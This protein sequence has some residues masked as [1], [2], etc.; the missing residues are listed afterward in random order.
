MS[1]IRKDLSL[2]QKL[3]ILDKI[4]LQPPGCSTRRLSEILGV[5]KSTIARI[6]LQEQ[7]LREQALSQ[8]TTRK[9]KRE[10]KDADVDEALTQWF[11]LATSRGVQ[12]SGPILK[13]KSEDLARSHGEKASANSEYADEWKFTKLP[14]IL[15]KF[16]FDDIYNA[17]ETGLYYRATPDGSLCFKHESIAGSKKAMDRITILCCV[18][19]SGTDKKKLLVIGKSKKPR[20]FQKM[21][22][23]KLPVEYHANKNAWM[24][25]AIFTDWLQRWDSELNKTKKAICLV[26]DNCT[27]HPNISLKNIKLE[28]LPPNTTSLIQPLDMGVIQNLKVKYRATLVNYI[29]EK[30]E[31][32]L[33]ESKS[34]AIDISKKI[35]IL[36]AIQF[37]SDSWR[38][39]EPNS[40]ENDN[41]RVLNNVEF[42]QLDSNVQCYDQNEYVDD[43]IIQS[44]Q[45][46]HNSDEDTDEEPDPP[47]RLQEAKKSLETLRL[48]FLQQGNEESPISALDTCSDYIRQQTLKSI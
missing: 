42:E 17:D 23:Q 25:S 28:F 41:V 1:R 21:S 34:T 2:A 46:Q 36:Q 20:C 27:A 35:N 18:N 38:D 9:R 3:D 26:L 44:I 22:L 30:I 14:Q 48:F 16:S 4:K 40:E 37:I 10:G 47:I 12:V 7:F 31:D 8:V 15:A 43:V 29:L 6:Q 33:L 13:A 5:S 19:A 45:Y 11:T 39:L 32:N 24:T